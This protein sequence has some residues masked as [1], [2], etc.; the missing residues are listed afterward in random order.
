MGEREDKQLSIMQSSALTQAS[1]VQV[2]SAILTHLV[3]KRRQCRRFFSVFVDRRARASVR[4]SVQTFIECLVEPRSPYH[5]G[6]P[7]CRV[8][9]FGAVPFALTHIFGF[10]LSPPL[11]QL[12]PLLR[13]QRVCRA[14]HMRESVLHTVRD[15]VVIWTRA[16]DTGLER[17]RTFS[18]R[19]FRRKATEKDSVPSEPPLNFR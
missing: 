19:S 9:L 12:P 13:R 1:H 10:F 5:E 16:A 14:I 11:G 4:V 8:K 3:P 18:G 6:A 2:K 15:T 17:C 7:L